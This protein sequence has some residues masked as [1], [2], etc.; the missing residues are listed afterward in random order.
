MFY[1]PPNGKFTSV[2]IT[3][4]FSNVSSLEVEG[5]AKNNENTN[6]NMTRDF[7]S[8][9]SF[10]ETNAKQHSSGMKTTSSYTLVFG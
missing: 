3:P 8:A 6:Y 5:M 10:P 4:S 2:H 7:R 1:M 9:I